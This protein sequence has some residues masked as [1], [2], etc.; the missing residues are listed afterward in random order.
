MDDN[1]KSA[2]WPRQ[3]SAVTGPSRLGRYEL[4]GKLATGGMAEIHLARLAGEAAF[5]NKVVVKR[6]RPELVA[7]P[8][9]VEMFVEEGKLVARLDHP[10]VCEVYELGRDGHEYFLVMPY[11]DGIPVNR[12]V[13]QVAFADRRAHLRMVCGVVAQACAGLH[14]AHELRVDEVWLGLVHRDV[15]PSNL[16]VTASGVVKVLDFGIAKINSGG[17]HTEVGVIKGKANYMAPEQVT[18]AP[19]DRRCDIFALGIVLFELVTRTRLFARDSDYLIARAILEEPIARA[20]HVDPSVPTAL[21]DV[22]ATALERRRDDRFVDARVFGTALE[23][24]LEPLGGIATPAEVAIMLRASHDD[25]LTAVR[26]RQ[27]AVLD[28]ARTASATFTPTI[29]MR[30]AEPRTR[31]IALRASLIVLT[32]GAAVAAFVLGRGSVDRKGAGPPS[33][34]AALAIVV[35]D[36]AVL[37]APPVAAPVPPPAPPA[38][39]GSASDSHPKHRRPETPLPGQISIDSTP[40]AKISDRRPCGGRHADLARAAGGWPSSRTRHARRRSY[41]RAH[42]HD[43]SGARGAAAGV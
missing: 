23:R 30:P 5:E 12:L 24:A 11:L 4:L 8:S 22:I 31:S 3:V 43:R 19:L 32:L 29:P 20:D 21:A 18:G 40:Y 7:S 42:D 1:S 33:S 35:N 27:A 6:L 38:T 39:N 2:G 36:A 17:T 25:E 10:N 26:A 9:L 37:P 13:S 14:H 34:D 15:S 41:G 28:H 16:F